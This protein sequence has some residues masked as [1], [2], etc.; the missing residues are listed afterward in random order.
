MKILSIRPET[1]AGSTIARFDVQVTPEIRLYN[2]KLV[3]GTRGR[4]VYAANA[5]GSSSATFAPALA[6]EIV[7]AASAAFDEQNAGVRNAA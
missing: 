5:F 2:C 3:Q 1:G 6:E 4:R 7:R